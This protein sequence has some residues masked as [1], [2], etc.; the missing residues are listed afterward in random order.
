M[1]LVVQ[2]ILSDIYRIE[3][4]SSCTAM[5]TCEQKQR[6]ALASQTLMQ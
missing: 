5:L 1:E 2:Y 6:Q 3:K 4:E